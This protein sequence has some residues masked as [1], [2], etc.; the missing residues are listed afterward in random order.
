MVSG[1]DRRA[2]R[3]GPDRFSFPVGRG[4]SGAA[5]ELLRRKNSA[6][7]RWGDRTGLWK[8]SSKEILSVCRACPLEGIE[9]RKQSGLGCQSRGAE[10]TGRLARESCRRNRVESN[11]C[12]SFPKDKI[13]QS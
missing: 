13:F 7:R 2:G 4:S 9:G 11:S 6:N 3:R 8:R 10:T 5:R 1:P 12:D